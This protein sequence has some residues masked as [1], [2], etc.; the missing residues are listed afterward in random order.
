MLKTCG[1]LTLTFGERKMSTKK[2]KGYFRVYTWD[3]DNEVFVNE[4]YLQHFS[5]KRDLLEEISSSF[6]DCIFDLYD[7]DDDDMAPFSCEKDFVAHVRK[8]VPDIWSTTD[9]IIECATGTIVEPLAFGLDKTLVDVTSRLW[10]THMTVRARVM[11]ERTERKE[12][13]ECIL[14]KLKQEMKK[15]TDQLAELN[16]HA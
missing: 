3:T 9:I 12:Q 7:D 1:K 16:K 14:G 4:S 10:S 11:K 8:Q 13:L 6:Y 2:L 15:V 5:N